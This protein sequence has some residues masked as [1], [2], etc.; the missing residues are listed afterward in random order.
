M[1]YQNFV[2]LAESLADVASPQS[3]HSWV[4]WDETKQHLKGVLLNHGVDV[5]NGVLNDSDEFEDF[6]RFEL[7][8]NAHFYEENEDDWGGVFALHFSDLEFPITTEDAVMAVEDI[9][10]QWLHAYRINSAAAQKEGDD[11]KFWD[12]RVESETEIGVLQEAIDWQLVRVRNSQILATYMN[13]HEVLER[14]A[15]V[16]RLKEKISELGDL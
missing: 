16:K 9:K 4:D 3:K 7:Y 10:Q 15:A 11:E 1:N 6:L 14:N 12:L 8:D 5:T 13:D 2:K